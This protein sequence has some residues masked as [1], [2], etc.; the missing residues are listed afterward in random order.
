[1]VELSARHK[2][3]VL[4]G[5][6]RLVRLDVPVRPDKGNFHARI[7]FFDFAD[8]LDVALEPYGGREEDQ[9][10]VVLA[11]FNRLLPIDFM[12]RGI[13]QAASGNHPR[14]IRQP[15]WVPVGY[16]LA[17][18]GPSRTCA[19][20]EIFET[21]R[22]QQQ[23][24]HDFRHSSPSAFQIRIWPCK[25]SRLAHHARLIV[26]TA[27]HQR[28]SHSIDTSLPDFV[29]S[30]QTFLSVGCYLSRNAKYRVRWALRDSGSS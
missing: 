15:D 27:A 9:K 8:E 2:I 7:G 16:N 28:E 17:R 26:A 1:M 10:F 13:E 21:R 30:P 19:A 29:A 12:R 24:L 20:V 3:D 22:I 25:T 14:G 18:R 5:H 11:D 6:Q 23:R 4:A